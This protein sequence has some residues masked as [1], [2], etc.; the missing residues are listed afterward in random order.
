MTIKRTH[1][2][3][4]NLTVNARIGVHDF[5]QQKPQRIIVNCDMGLYPDARQ[6][7]DVIADTVCYA[8]VRDKIIAHLTAFSF[9]LLETAAADIGQICLQDAR[10]KS[11]HIRIEKPDIFPDADAVGVAIDVVRGA[12][13]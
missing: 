7:I 6:N 11:A 3:I 12:D 2:Y 9:Q 1:I 10:V 4:K 5:E 13:S 8:T